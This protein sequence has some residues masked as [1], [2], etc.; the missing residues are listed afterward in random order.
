MTAN[1]EPVKEAHYCPYCDEEMA[2]AAF[3]YCQVC[4]VSVFYCPQC[5]RPLPRTSRSCPYCGADIRG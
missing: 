5:R 4:K 3:P 1:S 2:E